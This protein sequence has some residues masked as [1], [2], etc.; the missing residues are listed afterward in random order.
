MMH[1][2]SI[3]G[4]KGFYIVADRL[5]YEFHKL[6]NTDQKQ[7]SRRRRFACYFYKGLVCEG[8]SY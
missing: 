5:R 2:E 7:K 4:L 8:G 3:D 1:N 6:E